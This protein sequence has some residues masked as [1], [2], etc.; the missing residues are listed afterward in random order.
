MSSPKVW[1]ITGSSSGFGRNMT[2]FVLENGDIAVATLRKPEVLT[3]LAANHPPDKLLVL[4]LDVTKQEEI[5]AAFAAAVK[6]FGRVDVVFNNA[7]YAVLG[8]VEATPEAHVRALFDVNFFGALNVSKEAVRI[9]RDANKPQ[10]GRL[11][12]MSST[13]VYHGAPAM[14]ALSASKG[15]LNGMSES[16]ADELDPDWNIKVTLLEP[17]VFNTSAIGSVVRVEPPPAYTKP[18]LASMQTR[19]FFANNTFPP[20]V[21]STSGAVDAFYKVAALEDPPLHFSLGTDAIATAKKHA[22]DLLATVEK[23]SSFS[24]NLP[25]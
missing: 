7:G 17:G 4:K 5:N 20:G 23:V 15:A 3:D 19:S 14:G 10:G 6:R 2:E 9:F 25:V 24:S 12:Q 21:P 8:E 16:L 11:L 13:Y 1:F 18:A 22:I